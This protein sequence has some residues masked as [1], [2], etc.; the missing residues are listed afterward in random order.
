VGARVRRAR[1]KPRTHDP[2]VCTGAPRRAELPAASA[3]KSVFKWRA[4]PGVQN[5]RLHLLQKVCSNGRVQPQLGSNLVAAHPPHPRDRGQRVHRPQRDAGDRPASALHRPSDVIGKA[6]RVA[7]APRL[8]CAGGYM[9]PGA[10]R[11]W[12]AV[13]DPTSKGRENFS[14]RRC[15]CSPTAHRAPEGS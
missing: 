4:H 2:V 8:P 3:A 13:A 6:G 15:R 9:R 14:A 11:P 5:C 10:A 12:H 1:L 7:P